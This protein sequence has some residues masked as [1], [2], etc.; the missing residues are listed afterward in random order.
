MCFLLLSVIL[1]NLKTII[2]LKQQTTGDGYMSFGNEKG[3]DIIHRKEV[4]FFVKNLKDYFSNINK[5]VVILW[6]EEGII[7]EFKENGGNL[8]GYTPEQIEG[9]KWPDILTDGKDKEQTTEIN[10][11][12][13][14]SKIVRYY[15]NSIKDVNGTSKIFLW[16]NLKLENVQSDKKIFLSVGF[17]LDSID[18]LKEK[19][20]ESKFE[21]D[22]LNEKKENV[23]FKVTKDDLIL[24]QKDDTIRDYKSKLEFLAFYDE[25]TGLPNKNSLIRWLNLKVSQM[26]CIDTYLI[27]LEVR[28]LEKLNVTYGYDLVDELIIHISKRIKDIAGEGNKAFKIGFDRFAIICKSENISDFIERMLSQLLL[29]YNVNGNLI[30]VNF[31]IG[32][33]QIENSN[34]AAA[35]LMRR[36]DLAL[37]KAKEEGLNE[38]VIFKPSIEIQTLKEGILERE[39]RNGIEVNELIVFYQPF[40]KL[41]NDKICGFEALLRWYYLKSVFVSPLE[42]IPVAEKYG[43]IIDLG[44]MVLKQSLKAGK[45]LKKYYDDEFT[46]SINIS[47]K[48]FID[49]RFVK[50]TIEILENEKLQDIRLRFEITEKVAIENIDYTIRIMNEFKKYNVTFALDDFGVEYS[51]LNYLRKLPIE[52]VKIDKSFVQDI[53]DHDTYFIVETIVKLCK[54]LNLKTV[55]EGVETQRQYQII[56]ELGCD[57]AQ[58]YF[59]AKPLPINELINL[60]GKYKILE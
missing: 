54:K 27:F 16:C 11:K 5:Y 40:V 2:S 3:Q 18:N 58:G 4:E 21:L 17:N 6:D 34:E 26:D 14:N 23:E 51:S 29:P 49:K 25:L 45:I 52:A 35:N 59:I 50:N 19:T 8:L 47:P 55:I 41:E 28:D 32:A 53:N 39:R 22:T 33:A 36:C 10:K 38:Y 12:L 43:L 30:R 46:I 9:K 44:N 1:T 42:F 24:K 7:L 31:N 48:Q 13:V 57:Y 56:K 60:V 37:I 15:I 20:D